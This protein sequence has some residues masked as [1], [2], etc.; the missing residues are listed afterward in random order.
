MNREYNIIG[1]IYDADRTKA[2]LGANDFVYRWIEGLTKSGKQTAYWEGVHKADL[3]AMDAGQSV[4]TNSLIYQLDAPIEFEHQGPYIEITDFNNLPDRRAVL[5]EESV[6]DFDR[7]I[8][9]D[10]MPRP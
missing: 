3:A 5:G 1:T 10:R 4:M 7:W 9:M 8:G 6:S 2:W